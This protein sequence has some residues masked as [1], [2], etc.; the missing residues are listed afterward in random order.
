MFYCR[1]EELRKLN[2][3]YEES[4]FECVVIYGRRRVGKTSIINEFCKGK[5]TVFFSALLEGTA[6]DNLK[7]LSRAIY[8]YKEPDAIEGP[9]YNSFDSALDEITRL[10]EK[11]RIVFVIDEY[12][13]LAKSYPS[14]SSRLQH[15]IDHK[16]KD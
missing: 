7:T 2:K 15:L 13:Y 9:E 8:A 4:K 10:A 11:E 1:N 14:I 5:P 16:W 12:P 3:R 6:K